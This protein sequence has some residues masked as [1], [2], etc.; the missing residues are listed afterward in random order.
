MKVLCD[1]GLSCLLQGICQNDKCTD[2]GEDCCAYGDELKTCA[3][4]FFPV[5]CIQRLEPKIVPPPPPQ[6]FPRTQR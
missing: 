2:V 6:T 5:V 1:F 3:A 4:C